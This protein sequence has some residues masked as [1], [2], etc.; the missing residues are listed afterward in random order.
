MKKPAKLTRE[1]I[2]EGLNTIPL[3]NLILGTQGKERTLT[4]KQREFARQ[5]ALGETKAG[6]YR[7]AYNS[8]GKKLTQANEGSRLANRP[9]IAAEVIAYQAAIEAAKHRTPAQLRELVIHQLTRHALDEDVPPAQRIKSLELLGK[10]SEVAAFTE[11]KETTV[12]NQ[13]GELKEKLRQALSRFIPSNQSITDLSI[14]EPMTIDQPADDP[15]A[16]LLDE[17]R[18]HT[19]DDTTPADPTAPPPAADARAHEGATTHT[20]PHTQSTPKS[21]ST[22]AFDIASRDMKD[23]P[24]NNSFYNKLELEVVGVSKNILEEELIDFEEVPPCDSGMKG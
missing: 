20:I 12:I 9:D 18:G 6:A 13:S 19:I 5:V 8:K 17:I 22:H 3:E 21:D 23:A 4:P 11:R 24:L 15:A 2:R 14:N 7:Q 16:S 10:V 1:Q